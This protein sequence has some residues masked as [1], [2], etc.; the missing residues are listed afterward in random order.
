MNSMICELVIRIYLY[1]FITKDKKK[2]MDTNVKQ[3]KQQNQDYE[4]F[5]LFWVDSQKKKKCNQRQ[6]TPIW[7]L[8]KIYHYHIVDI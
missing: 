5:Q 8:C 6:K 1:T 3:G 7:E 2:N 4:T